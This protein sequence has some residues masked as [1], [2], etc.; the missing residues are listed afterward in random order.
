MKVPE[1]DPA[2]FRGPLGAVVKALDPITEASPVGTLGSL[3]AAFSAVLGPDVKV[4][5]GKGR[6]NLSTGIVLVGR[7]GIGRKGTASDLMLGVTGQA[8]KAWQANNLIEGMPATALGLL[9]ELTDKGSALVYEQECDSM[10][11]SMKKDPKLGVLLRKGYDGATLSHRTSQAD[12]TVKKPHFAAIVHAQPKN[13]AK[14]FG[15]T[16]ATGGSFN[17]Y[18]YLAV[19]RSKTLPV[20]AEADNDD[21][22]AEQASKLRRIAAFA[23]EVDCV[24]IGK[25]EAAKFEKIHRPAVEA[26]L[27]TD[28][29]DL[30]QMTERSM[31]YMIRIAALY[32]L[33]D[34]RDKIKSKD[35]DSAL[36]LVRYSVESLSALTPHADS[37]VGK[38]ADIVREAGEMSRSE[39]SDALGHNVPARAISNA[40][41]SLPQIMETKGISNGGR[42]PT[43]LKWVDEQSSTEEADDGE[44]VAA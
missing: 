20:F 21:L 41:L 16:D 40:L 12:V 34:L 15:S 35:L 42:R 43:I 33:A 36:A 13:L 29:D 32:A 18:L 39:L 44:T 2:A 27:E 8:W 14:V 25:K 28:N 10:I 26:L 9:G 23:R 6:M 38:I 31:A 24:T 4:K 1:M 30:S 22:I 3:L 5:T 17:R 19:E 7:T 37:L 11:R